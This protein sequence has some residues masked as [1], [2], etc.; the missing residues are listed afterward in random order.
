MADLLRP[1]RS[2]FIFTG[3]VLVTAILYWAQAVVVPIAFAVLMA[4]LLTPVVSWLQRWIGRVPA[5][6]SV[7]VLAFAGLGLVGWL[8][9]RQLSGLVEDLPT[10]QRNIRQ[11][12]L[13][14]RGASSGGSL[15]KLQHAV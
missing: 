10:Y 15:D 7:V 14:L 6:I 9:T 13:D 1:S 3:L 11:K 2:W 8:V 5:V 12:I 4:F